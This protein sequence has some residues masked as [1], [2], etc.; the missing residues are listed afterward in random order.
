MA[1][2]QH[3]W[4]TTNIRIEED[5]EEKVPMNRKRLIPILT[6]AN[7]ITDSSGRREFNANLRFDSLTVNGKVYTINTMDK[8]PEKLNP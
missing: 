7:K 6:A 5:F 4:N 1:K 8:L 3:I 2:S